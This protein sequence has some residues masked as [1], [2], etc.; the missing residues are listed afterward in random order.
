MSIL[1]AAKET[2]AYREIV[3]LARV[4]AFLIVAIVM[5]G[6]LAPIVSYAHPSED[7][8]IR[9][10]E[11]QYGRPRP[12]EDKEPTTA[13]EAEEEPPGFVQTVRDYLIIGFQHILPKG[14][15]HILF[16]L[17]L[18]LASTRFR[19]LLIQVTTFTVAHTVTLALAILG[20]IAVP[21]AVVEPLIALSIAFVAIENVFFDKMTPWRP[22]VVFGFGLLH[23]LGFAGVL[24]EIGMPQGQF[25]TGLISFNVGVEF[26]QLSVIMAAWLIL[27]HFYGKPWFRQRVAIPASIA[28]AVVGLFWTAERIYPL[29]A[30]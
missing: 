28:I 17:G 30:G 21:G 24:T 6:V 1:C 16:V 26:G 10:L 23:G 3:V 27:H 20:F 18:F 2:A 19:P 11:E 12:S 5:A 4:L 22:V 29:I 8:L 15:D 25:I 7:E 14:T 9:Q 13:A